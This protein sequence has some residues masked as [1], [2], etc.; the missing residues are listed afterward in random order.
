MWLYKG[1]LAIT[2]LLIS[3][4][5]AFFLQKQHRGRQSDS[6]LAASIL[7]WCSCFTILN[8]IWVPRSSSVFHPL[9]VWPRVPVRP[10]L[11]SVHFR[12]ITSDSIVLSN[13]TVAFRPETTNTSLPSKQ[14]AGQHQV[15]PMP[16][17]LHWLSIV[18]EKWRFGKECWLAGEQT[19]G[20]FI[21]VAA[22]AASLELYPQSSW[23]EYE[24][25][26]VG[27]GRVDR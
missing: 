11:F 15:H 18:W 4:V 21:N 5:I 27:E 9:S 24:K 10:Q 19:P 12:R 23:P 20:D 25:E 17:A 26:D 14:H 22:D 13:S 6:C 16:L 2:S 1:G 3:S 7:S 8:H